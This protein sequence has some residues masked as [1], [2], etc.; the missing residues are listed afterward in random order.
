MNQQWTPMNPWLVVQ[1]Q[2]IFKHTKK[3]RNAPRQA[4]QIHPDVLCCTDAAELPEAPLGLCEAVAA[5][6]GIKSSATT[7]AQQGGAPGSVQFVY[8]WLNY[9]LW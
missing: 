4:S 7:R 8:K 5:M 6:G 2:P 1:K 3:K 9:G